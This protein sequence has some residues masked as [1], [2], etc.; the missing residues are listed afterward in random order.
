[1]LPDVPVERLG[2]DSPYFEKMGDDKLKVTFFT[3]FIKYQ[4]KSNPDFGV[5]CYGCVIL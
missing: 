4:R 1:V 2:S 5:G 3:N